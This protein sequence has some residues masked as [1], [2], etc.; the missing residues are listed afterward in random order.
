MASALIS[1]ALQAG[2][3]KSNLTVVDPNLSQREA[4]AA[5]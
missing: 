3:S 4:L 2:W 5:K 1:G